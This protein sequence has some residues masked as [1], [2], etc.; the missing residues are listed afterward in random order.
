MIDVAY[1]PF[2]TNF[3]L[4]PDV[5]F[6]D[7]A[8]MGRTAERAA[9][10]ENDPRERWFAPLL[11]GTIVPAFRRTSVIDLPSRSWQIACQ[12]DLVLSPTPPGKSSTMQVNKPFGDCH[13]DTKKKDLFILAGIL[14]ALFGLVVGALAFV[15]RPALGVPI[16][17]LGRT[18]RSSR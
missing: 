16:D 5:S 18:G 6:R 15:L 17:R 14:L 9:A 2:A 11:G 12:R 4:G 13:D 7:E 10:V 3:S 1:G 8:K